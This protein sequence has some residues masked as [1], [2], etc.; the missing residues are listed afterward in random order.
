[1]P[2]SNTTSSTFFLSLLTSISTC[3]ILT[4]VAISK[5]KYGMIVIP[6][7]EIYW[8]IE[9][10]KWPNYK[11]TIIQKCNNTYLQYARLSFSFRQ[12]VI[13]TLCKRGY[14]S[15]YQTLNLEKKTLNNDAKR[16]APL[17][18]IYFSSMLG[19]IAKMMKS[20]KHCN[21][22]NFYQIAFNKKAKL[23]TF[24]LLKVKL[25]D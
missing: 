9:A 5:S 15:Y 20:W 6:H 4:K 13:S 2:H 17:Y 8:D 12:L 7:R 16:S 10:R 24:Y 22:V 11:A 1:M 25:I 18:L 14:Q 3:K 21:S 23:S 19:S